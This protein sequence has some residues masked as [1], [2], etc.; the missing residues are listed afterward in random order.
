MTSIRD[1]VYLDIERVRSLVSQLEE[2][3]IETFSKSL[4]SNSKVSGNIKGGILGIASG[5][6]GIEQLWRRD[7]QENRSL[8]DFLYTR[9]EDQLVKEGLVDRIN[10]ESIDEDGLEGFRS[11]LSSTQ[12]LLLDAQ[13]ELNDLARMN[14]L[15]KKF[16]DLGKFFAWTSAQNNVVGDKNKKDLEYHKMLKDPDSNF[17]IDKRLQ[18]GLSQVIEILLSEKIVLRAKPFETEFPMNFVGIL[19]PDFLREDM[20]TPAWLHPDQLVDLRVG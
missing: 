8:N 14:A 2:G 11:G 17:Q 10:S 6:S 13:V 1:F 15:F 7:T 20:A 5:E 16:N 4:G 9:L 18:D 12:F 19:R 3:V